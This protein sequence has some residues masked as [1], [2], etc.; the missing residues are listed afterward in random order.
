MSGRGKSKAQRVSISTRAGTIFPVS[1]IRRYLKGCTH[2]QRIAVGAP[3]Y[4][5]AV[6]EYLSAEI[7]ELAGNAARDNKRTRITPR[8]IL[9]AVANDEELN[10]L[11]KN[12]TIPAGGVMPHIQPE[13]LKRKDGGKF[14]VPKN[15]AAVRAALQKAKNAGIQKAK[16]KPKPVVK[17]KA[18][19]ASKS[20]VKK[21]T[22]PKKK[23]ESKGSDSIAVLSEKTLFLGQKLTIVQ[24]NMES[25]KCD[26]LVHPTNATFNTTGEVGAALLKVGGEDLK[27]NI[28]ALHESHGDL[29]YATALVG[30]APNLQAKHIIHV[31]S[32]VWGKGKAEDDLETVVKNALTLADEKNLTTIAF[33]SIGSGVGPVKKESNQFPKQT[34]AQTILKAIS[35]YFVTVVTSS[36]RQIYFVLHDMESI[37]VYSLELARLETSENK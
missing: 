32:P 5:A 16:N 17:A 13:L 25:L 12:V 15:D 14:V 26:A 7:L 9:L 3:I 4:Q 33:P 8:H 11:L 37:G 27:K 35:N 30:E 20:P 2:H 31:Y 22:T 21:V 28:I 18:P 34:A 36:L 23:A 29:A 10:K 19:V 24:G 6:M 1:R